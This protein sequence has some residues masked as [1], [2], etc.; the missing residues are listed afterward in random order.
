MDSIHLTLTEV[1]ARN[2]SCKGVVKRYL[3]KEAT[4]TSPWSYMDWTTLFSVFTF[5]LGFKLLTSLL[6]SFRI[7][8]ISCEYF[9]TMRWM[10][11]FQVSIL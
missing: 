3:S 8:H 7:F 6:Q 1:V 4:V 10:R 2:A 11:I 9:R 5:V